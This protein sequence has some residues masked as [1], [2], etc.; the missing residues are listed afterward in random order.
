[1]K[2]VLYVAQGEK[3]LLKVGR[4][5]KPKMRERSLGFEFKHFGDTLRRFACTEEMEFV[6][7]SESAAIILAER[8]YQK[9]H[10]R[11][12]FKAEP[13]S[14]VFEAAYRILLRARREREKI[15]TPSWE[16]IFKKRKA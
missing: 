9:A 13:T 12:W 4:T 3:G 2:A 16:S 7:Q 8:R 6:T 11:E 5:I 14:A 15:L 1:M 10:G